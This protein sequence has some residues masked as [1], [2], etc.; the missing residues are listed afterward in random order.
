DIQRHCQNLIVYANCNTHRPTFFSQS[1]LP[2]NSEQKV[3]S[4]QRRHKRKRKAAR[5]DEAEEILVFGYE[6]HIFNDNPTAKKIENGK[7][8]IPWQ[9]VKKDP[10][11][12][13]RYDA[14][15]LLDDLMVLSSRKSVNDDCEEEEEE[16]DAERFADLD[17]DEEKLFDMSDED[18]RDQYVEEKRKRRK[19]EEENKAFQYSYDSQNQSN[20]S[21]GGLS[22]EKTIEEPAEEINCSFRIPDDIQKPKTQKQVDVIERTAK[23]IATSASESSHM[24]I[25]IQ[26][27]QASNPMFAFLNKDHPLHKFYKHV[28]WLSKSGL[29][30]YGSSDS[31]SDSE[32]Q[33]SKSVEGNVSSESK[34]EQS[35]EVE[36]NNADIYEVITKTAA[37]V[38][39]AGSSLESKI[40][41][42]NFGNPKFAFLNPWNELHA[43]YRSQ[44]DYFISQGGADN[45]MQS[46][47][48]RQ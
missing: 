24:E 47:P 11:L 9:G 4:Y 12:L 46:P 16:L 36:Q 14:R 28:L 15:N 7:F 44:V 32:E 8:L 39:K 38:A 30:G 42:K 25:T 27:K 23:F 43:Y 13:D 17:S 21:Q 18:E 20:G 35:G 1:L 41:E 19:M 33:Q 3:K 37:F 2:E 6:A 31:E 29:A 34:S 40:K 22:E 48:T 5:S 10:I 45:S 26:A